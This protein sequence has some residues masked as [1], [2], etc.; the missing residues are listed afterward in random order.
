MSRLR[1]IGVSAYIMSNSSAT[2]LSCLEQEA[3]QFLIWLP[4]AC[5]AVALSSVLDRVAQETYSLD[6]HFEEIARLHENR[7]LARRPNATGCSGDDHIARLQTHRD[8]DHFD[9]RGDAED[10]L[11]G[12]RILH[13]SA[14][15]ASLNA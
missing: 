15:Q 10:E 3:Q 8:A 12:T 14:V 4:D 5:R 6:L 2:P 7:W 11:V 13:H 9:E 1:A